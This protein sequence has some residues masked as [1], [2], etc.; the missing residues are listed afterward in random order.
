MLQLGCVPWGWV[1]GWMVAGAGAA[2]H[3]FIWQARP[4]ERLCVREAAPPL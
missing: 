2:S 4:L 3:A 1:G